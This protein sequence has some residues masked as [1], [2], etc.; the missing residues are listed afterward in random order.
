MTMS[1]RP[2]VSIAI[3][4]TYLAGMPRGEDVEIE[5]KVARVRVLA[6]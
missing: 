4:T 1:T 5:A 2:G 3:T 6:D